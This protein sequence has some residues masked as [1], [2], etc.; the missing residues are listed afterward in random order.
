MKK[1]W[2]TPEL[3]DLTISATASTD[4]LGWGK[5]P[6]KHDWPNFPINPPCPQKPG[7]PSENP[8]PENPTEELS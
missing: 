5:K 7:K 4:M 2:S 8:I 3:Q 6:N 1:T